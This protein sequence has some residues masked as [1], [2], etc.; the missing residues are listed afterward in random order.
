MKKKSLQ[1]RYDGWGDQYDEWIDRTSSRLAVYKSKYAIMQGDRK[2]I[3]EGTMQKEGKMFKTWRRR[4]FKLYD[5]GDMSYYNA[6]EDESALGS[7]NVKK[8]KQTS[9]QSYGRSKEYGF[10]VETETRCWKFI[11]DDEQGQ[12]EWVNAVNFVQRGKFTE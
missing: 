6:K 9:K 5:N 3:K 12:N 10:Q 4:Y 2:I 1:I 7:I 8:M 11:C